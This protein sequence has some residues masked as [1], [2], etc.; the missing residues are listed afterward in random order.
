MPTNLSKTDN[1][2]SRLFAAKTD[3]EARRIIKQ[4]SN[5]TEK[6]AIKAQKLRQQYSHLV[7]A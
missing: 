3:K 5:R 2:L 4:I 6:L 7:K 1:L